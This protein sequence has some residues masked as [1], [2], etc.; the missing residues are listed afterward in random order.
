VT[1]S[2]ST[3]YSNVHAA[4]ANIAAAKKNHSEYKGNFNSSSQGPL[5]DAIPNHMYSGR[6][7]E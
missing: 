4:A 6:I 2:V 3:M 5:H 1:L 7:G